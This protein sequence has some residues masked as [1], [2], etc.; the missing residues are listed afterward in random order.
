MQPT[1]WPEP[2]DETTLRPS[3]VAQFTR[4]LYALIGALLGACVVAFVEAGVALQAAGVTRIRTLV[5][6]ATAELGVLAPAT[7]FVG[8]VVA[9][10]SIFL[11]PEGPRG[12]GEHFDA[13]RAEPILS[14]RGTY[15]AAT[16]A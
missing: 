13:I 7:L 8:G 6:L 5:E 10:V 12:P 14:R 4:V 15:C 16:G 2:S 1:R 11:E 3:V 9:V